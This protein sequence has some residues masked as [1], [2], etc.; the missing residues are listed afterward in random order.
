VAKKY[1]KVITEEE[2]QKQLKEAPHL[3]AVGDKVRI[4]KLDKDKYY[5]I[6]LKENKNIDLKKVKE[7]FIKEIEG[8]NMAKTGENNLD[9]IGQEVTIARIRKGGKYKGFYGVKFE[10]SEENYGFIT[11]EGY[12][13]LSPEKIK[14]LKEY[15]RTH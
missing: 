14:E 15:W 4:K 13:E 10:D 12:L 8:I 6:M 2:Y 11:C 1:G 5:P 9:N 3:F 7:G